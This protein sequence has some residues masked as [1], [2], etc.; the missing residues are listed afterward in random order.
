LDPYKYGVHAFTTDYPNIF[1]L[2][3]GKTGF[4]IWL[5]AI[6]ESQ[7]LERGSQGCVV[8]RNDTIKKLAQ[9]LR[10]EKHPL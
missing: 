9:I 3:K 7:T 1:D 10:L 4:G 2:R 6:D 5:H 8:V